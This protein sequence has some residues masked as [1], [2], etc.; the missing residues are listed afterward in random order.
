MLMHRLEDRGE[1][2]HAPQ[3]GPNPFA[4]R[5]TVPHPLEPGEHRRVGQPDDPLAQRTVV[6]GTVDEVHDGDA[7]AS[8]LR[9]TAACSI[10]TN[11]HSLCTGPCSRRWREA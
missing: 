11:G 7:T 9:R 10:M 5:R 1:P 2:V 6:C 4:W 3:F 8:D